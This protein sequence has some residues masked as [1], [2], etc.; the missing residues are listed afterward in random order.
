MKV[1]YRLAREE[2]LEPAH[3]AMLESLNQFATQRGMPLVEM[4][5][6]DNLPL[7]RHFLGTS[8]EGFLVAEVK[9]RLAGFC[10]YIERGDLWFLSYLVVAPEFQGT[11]M[12]RELF[13][14]ALPEARGNKQARVLAAYTNA[15]NW[16]SIS[17]YTRNGIFP[18]TPILKLEGDISGLC[19]A[20]REIEPLP[21]DIV[22]LSEETV[23]LVDDIDEKVRGFKRDIDHRFWLGASGMRCYLF[24]K[25]G[26]TAGYAYIADDGAI[27]PVAALKPEDMENMLCF[28]LDHL[29][30]EGVDRFTLH[31]P[32]ENTAALS[33]LYDRGFK[34][35][36]LSLLLSS[37]PFG[38]WENYI[39]SRPSL[40]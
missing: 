19:Q 39:I 7:W 14:R 23:A 10:C 28:C 18:R 27:G 22:S 3:R 12:G 15:S 32:G 4:D 1:Q 16:P 8:G 6:E 34:I 17:L 20:T 25:D 40:L 24:K 35:Q 30:S 26:N 38:K 2:D 11:G 29:S 37:L 21:G 13:E 31:V 36:D 33:L 5:F 9:K